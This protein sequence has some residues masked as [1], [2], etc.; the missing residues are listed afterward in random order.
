MYIDTLIN[1]LI[2]C[3]LLAVCMTV[4]PVL[5]YQ[6]QLNIMASQ[7]SR[8]ISISGEYNDSE[9]DEIR[10]SF[11]S[12]GNNV[13]IEVMKDGSEIDENNA[14]ECKIQLSDKFSV[15]LSYQ[16]N[17]TL[18]GMANSNITLSANSTG[19]SEVFWKELPVN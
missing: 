17:V 16:F 6:Y 18:G 5:V 14:D 12:F 11:G 7:I 1:M 9:V 13:S 4:L 3:I 8:T 15:Q 19:R 10:N 2:I